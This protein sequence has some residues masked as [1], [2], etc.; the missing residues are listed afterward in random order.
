M[1]RLK[2]AICVATA[3]LFSGCV[4]MQPESE[5]GRNCRAAEVTTFT[6]TTVATLVGTTVGGPVAIVPALVA[7][8][9]VANTHEHC[10]RSE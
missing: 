4:T 8:A 5:A 10:E 3:L 7:A 1:N 6:G 2:I 9:G